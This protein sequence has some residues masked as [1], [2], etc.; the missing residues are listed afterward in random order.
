[1]YFD[2]Q[3]NIK[4]SEFIFYFIVFLI[5]KNSDIFPGFSGAERFELSAAFW[6][7]I[8]FFRQNMRDMDPVFES[9]NPIH[10]CSNSY[11]NTPKYT[12]KLQISVQKHF[13]A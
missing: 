2:T 4:K 5:L 10:F 13:F 8:V 7:K 11:K 9:I 3:E 12:S 1:M 6:H